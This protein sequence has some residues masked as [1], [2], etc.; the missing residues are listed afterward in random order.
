MT[1]KV[2]TP[3]KKGDMA[4]TDGWKVRQQ[5]WQEGPLRISVAVKGERE[6]GEGRWLERCLDLVLFSST[7]R[8]EMVEGLYRGVKG[9]IWE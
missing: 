6:L 2:E 8:L 5:G 4:L 3:V 9:E 1:W 7:G